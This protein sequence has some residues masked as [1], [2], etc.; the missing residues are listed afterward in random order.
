MVIHYSA[1]LS[2]DFHYPVIC[3][4]APAISPILCRYATPPF[5]FFEQITMA[6]EFAVR[7]II[8]QAKCRRRAFGYFQAMHT[9][10]RPPSRHYLG[11]DIIIRYAMLS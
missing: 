1:P 8:C 11:R 5:V 10:M 7:G 6:D 3:S 9:F 2:R 4:F